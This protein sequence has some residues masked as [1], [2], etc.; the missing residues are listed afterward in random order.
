MVS[1]VHTEQPSGLHLREGGV[2]RE[3]ESMNKVN[4]AGMHKGVNGMQ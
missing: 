3:T 1:F 4:T 2:A